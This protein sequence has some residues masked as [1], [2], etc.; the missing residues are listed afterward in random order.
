MQ[1]THEIGYKIM[2][3]DDVSSVIDISDLQ[4]NPTSTKRSGARTST[5]SANT[6]YRFR[7][8]RDELCNEK[9]TFW[10]KVNCWVTRIIVLPPYSPF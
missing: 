1:E 10:A 9:I 7:I 4:N 5:T 3:E 8:Q 2:S 6:L